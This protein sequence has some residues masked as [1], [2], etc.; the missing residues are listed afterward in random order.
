MAASACSGSSVPSGRATPRVSSRRWSPRIADQPISDLPWPLG[1]ALEQLLHP[2]L[3]GGD[4]VHQRVAGAD[5]GVQLADE[6]GPAGGW[7]GALGGLGHVFARPEHRRPRRAR[8]GRRPAARRLRRRRRETDTPSASSGARGRPSTGAR[9]HRAAT[10]SPAGPRRNVPRPRAASPGKGGHIHVAPALRGRWRAPRLRS[11]RRLRALADTWA[12]VHARIL[13]SPTAMRDRGRN[14]GGEAT[15]RSP[16]SVRRQTVKVPKGAQRVDGKGRTLLAGFWNVHVHFT[17]PRFAQAATRP[18]AELSKGCR[19]MLT[20]RGFT[21]VVDLGSLPDNTGALQKRQPTLDCPRII[22]VGLSHASRWTA[23]PST[24][25]ESSGEEMAATLPQPRTAEEAAAVVRRERRPRARGPSRS[26]RNLAGGSEDRGDEAGG[27]ARRHRRGAS[28]GPAGLRPSSVGRGP[29]G[30]DGGRGR[31]PGPHRA[32]AARPGARSW[33]SGWSIAKM[34]LAPTLSLWRVEMQRSQLPQDV[35][36]ALHRRGPRPAP[37]LRRRARARSSSAP[38]SATSPRRAPTR[39]WPGWPTPGWAGRTSSAAWARRRRGASGTPSRGTLQPGGAADL[40]LVDGDPRPDGARPHPRPADLGCREIRLR[41]VGLSP[42]SRK[43]HAKN[44]GCPRST[45]SLVAADVREEQ[46][47]DDLDRARL[48]DFY[49]ELERFR[50][51]FARAQALVSPMIGEDAGRLEAMGK[52]I[53]KLYGGAVE[54]LMLHV[55]EVLLA[56]PAHDRAA[57]RE[58]AAPGAG[59]A[60]RRRPPTRRSRPARAFLPRPGEPPPP[61][62]RCRWFRCPLPTARPTFRR[63]GPAPCPRRDIPVASTCPPTPPRPRSSPVPIE[64]RRASPACPTR[65]RPVAPPRSRPPPW[66][67]ATVPAIRREPAR[68]PRARAAPHLRGSPGGWGAG[69][70]ATRPPDGPPP[71]DRVRRPGLGRRRPGAAP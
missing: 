45:G 68:S 50:A 61:C 70:S 39:R 1:D 17:D 40:V 3:L 44:L 60:L 34:S 2:G 4:Q 28:G 8:S 38:T 23:S 58:P 12:V 14:P 64:E 57:S 15:G 65:G 37:G 71:A 51:V 69:S 32:R 47:V 16:P 53:R 43:C 46:R 29:P 11:A 13:P 49:D 42:T 31:R 48:Q 52:A 30:R 67:P 55:D 24:S 63:S 18:A 27:R 10:K 41:S 35:R 26:S 36:D 21:T 62:C 66:P 56:G 33:C 7:E 20:S 6:A 59:A 5:E 19:E 54:P 25:S 9:R 22:S